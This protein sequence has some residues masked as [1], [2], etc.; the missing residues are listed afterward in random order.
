[1]SDKTKSAEYLLSMMENLELKPYF[2]FLK[3]ILH[4]F[5]VFNAFFQSGET[6]IHLLQLK[7]VNFLF[8][9]CQ[10]FVKKE[11][12]HNIITNIN[13]NFSHSEEILKNAN[14]IFVGSDCEEHLNYLMT[15]GHIDV[16]KTVR[17]N[18]REFYLTAADEIRKRLPITNYFLKN[19]QVFGPAVSIWRQ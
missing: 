16:V 18:C 1:M 5:N 7:S 9:I 4:F 10:N 6:R 15:K 19:L 11:H 3:Y 12:L 17:Q 8:Q 13:I 2:L 14:E